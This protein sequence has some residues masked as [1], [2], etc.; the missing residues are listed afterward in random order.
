MKIAFRVQ[1]VLLRPFPNFR[2]LN[3]F[4]F[5]NF[6][7]PPKTQTQTQALGLL[8]CRAMATVKERIELTETERKIFDRLL[9]SLRH[10]GLTNQLRVAGGWVRDKVRAFELFGSVC[11]S[12]KAGNG[13]I[14]EPCEYFLKFQ[15]LGFEF[16]CSF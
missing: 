16:I 5:P 2:I 3:P 10:F 7:A 11:F 9:G 12:F 6:Y 4:N 14:E 15:C 1:P 8:H 13:R